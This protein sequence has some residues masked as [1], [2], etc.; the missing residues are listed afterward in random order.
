MRK[1]ILLLSVLTIFSV[2]ASSPLNASPPPAN[3]RIESVLAF[4]NSYFMAFSR[5]FYNMEVQ[6]IDGE[7][8]GYKLGGDADDTANGRDNHIGDDAGKK[9]K[10]KS[11]MVIDDP[12]AKPKS[13]MRTY[14]LR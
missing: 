6:P 13:I 9:N 7:D 8:N 3:Y 5:I 2:L 1:V 4:F 10:V 12:R 11:G 14:G